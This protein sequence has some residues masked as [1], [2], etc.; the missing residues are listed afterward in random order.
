ME[1]KAI[2]KQISNSLSCI[3]EFLTN[4]GRKENRVTDMPDHIR[5]QLF[6]CDIKCAIR[7]I[8]E[9]NKYQIFVYNKNSGSGRPIIKDIKHHYPEIFNCYPDFVYEIKN[10]DEDMGDDSD[11]FEITI[12]KT[13]GQE[14]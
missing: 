3:E 1:N 14:K 6:E 2:D 13:N 9:S 4:E 8:N 10:N 12:T 7:I 11:D 5:K